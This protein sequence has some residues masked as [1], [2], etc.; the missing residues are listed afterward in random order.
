MG[1]GVGGVGCWSW[2]IWLVNTWAAASP[3]T[4][5]GDWEGAVS[6]VLLVN[7]VWWTV[8]G[9]TDTG[10]EMVCMEVAVCSNV[11]TISISVHWLMMH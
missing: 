7:L 1:T 11:M 5:L 2:R 3:L 9:L 10:E 4:W 8:T 6:A